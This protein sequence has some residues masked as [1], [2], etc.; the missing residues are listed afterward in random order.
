MA[1]W[2]PTSRPDPIR[3][4]SFRVADFHVSLLSRGNAVSL[5]ARFG[6]A[7]KDDLCRN[8]QFAI[9]A[10]RQWFLLSQNRTSICCLGPEGL[11]RRLSVCSLPVSK[12]SVGSLGR[13]LSVAQSATCK[14][15]Q[16]A[17]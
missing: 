10:S 1:G 12:Q 3:W 15:W 7:R 2:K 5:K 16:S 14:T 4:G 13:F 17:L 8:T 11:H 9:G 6:E